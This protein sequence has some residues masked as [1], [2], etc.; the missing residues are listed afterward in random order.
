MKNI[1][2]KT[3][4]ALVALSVTGAANAFVG[5][6]TVPGF[7]LPSADVNN[8]S[9][10]EYVLSVYD[11]TTGKSF[12]ADLGIAYNTTLGTTAA[13]TNLLT[14]NQVTALNTVFLDTATGTLA[15][16]LRYS[17]MAADSK[18]GGASIPEFGQRML[19]TSTTI[20]G[21]FLNKDVNQ[22]TLAAD[23]WVGQLNTKLTHQ[24]PTNPNGWSSATSNFDST[25]WMATMGTSGWE[26]NLYV[27]EA[28]VSDS[29]FFLA[30]DATVTATT[31]PGIGTFPAQNAGDNATISYLGNFT[32]TGNGN[33]SYTAVASAVPL[34]AAVWLFGAGLMGLVGV[35]RR[36]RETV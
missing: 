5:G 2:L 25:S 22:A 6:P 7:T 9:G 15:A 19:T 21:R 34:P 24:D 20:V 1:K 30:M 3:L 10:S 27:S 16:G 4:A 8:T 35:A 26:Q 32:L 29:L 36:R 31:I 28:L 17:I 23:A 11:Q 33:L 14:A 18:L 12:S 13:G